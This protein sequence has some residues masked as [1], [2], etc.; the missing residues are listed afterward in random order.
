L[1]VNLDLY[2]NLEL[3][4]DV[5]LD[6]DMELGLMQ[7]CLQKYWNLNS[8]RALDGEVPLELD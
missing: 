7:G 2:W 4:L 1:D 5:N 8:V 6:L 3:E